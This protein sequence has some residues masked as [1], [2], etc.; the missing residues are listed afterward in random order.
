M[1]QP[2][3]V[4]GSGKF[5]TTIVRLLAL[6]GPV[7]WYVRNEKTAEAISNSREHLNYKLPDNILI[8]TDIQ[9]LTTSCQV[10]FPVIPSQFVRGMVRSI[11][12]IL[13]PA[14]I[15]IHG[16]K[17]LDTEGLSDD[18]I[19]H[20][21]LSRQHVH[22]ISEVIAQET[23][24]KRIG[25]LSGPNLATEILEDQPTATVIASE[26]E[27]VIQIGKKW[28][29]SRRF[30]VFG[31]NDIIGAE[32]AGALK[33]IIAIGSGLLMGRGY[34]KNIQAMLITRGLREM[35]SFGQ[36]MGASPGS[37]FGTSGLGDLIA[38]ATSELSR[39]FTLGERLAKGEDLET[40]INSSDETAEGVR[41]LRIAQQ[42]AKYYNIHVPIT[43]TLY[44][45]VY[46][47]Q[48][49]DESLN[50][51]MRYPFTQDVDFI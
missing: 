21:Q 46:E 3:G 14:H 34:G 47:G 41:T 37:F 19:M 31:S 24:V 11:S 29:S 36:A 13:T 26:F 42:L 18:E 6:N 38:T 32:I 27:E 25:C 39:N 8:T 5:G 48:E 1:Q 30:Y 9:H 50:Y 45:I 16:T 10:I 12:N 43:E 51:L 44:K 4:I 2:A 15:L 28:L 23:I 33:N 20:V 22:T 7:I 35:I 40:V 49:I 17:G